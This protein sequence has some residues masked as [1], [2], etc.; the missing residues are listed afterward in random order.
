VAVE[1]KRG[2]S[3]PADVVVANLPPWNIAQL[4]GDGA[5]RRST[6]GWTARPS[7]PTTPCTIRSW[8]RNRWPKGTPFF[9]RLART[10][11]AGGRRPVNER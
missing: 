9:C 3:F 10:G 4:L 5:P 2:K 11:M 1:T 7:P 8:F 6:S